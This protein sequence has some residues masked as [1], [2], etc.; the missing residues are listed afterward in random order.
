MRKVAPFLELWAVTDDDRL[1]RVTTD[2]LAQNGATPS[3]LAWQVEVGNRKV[4]RRTG[5]PNDAITAKI[6]GITDHGEHR[7]RGTSNN[8]VAGAGV[9]SVGDEPEQY[10]RHGDEEDALVR[11]GWADRGGHGDWSMLPLQ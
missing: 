11:I 6:S 3:A 1:V 2:L 10:Q 5:D 9:G 8:F 4:E 7:L